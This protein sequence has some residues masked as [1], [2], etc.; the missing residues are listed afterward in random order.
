MFIAGRNLQIN[1]LDQ[2]YIHIVRNQ[3]YGE[4]GISR[5][6]GTTRLYI[7][8]RAGAHDVGA[9]ANARNAVCVG[10]GAIQTVIPVI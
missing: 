3:R 7:G 2:R 5:H 1:G 9:I 10:C 6:Y 4:F 8:R